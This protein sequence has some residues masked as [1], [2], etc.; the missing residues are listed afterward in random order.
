[1]IEAGAC[2]DKFFATPALELR[3]YKGIK[4]G[5]EVY[6]GKWTGFLASQMTAY[7]CYSLIN[8]TTLSLP[9]YTSNMG[10]PKISGSTKITEV[11]DRG[12]NLLPSHW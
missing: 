5:K 3:E 6:K 12:F 4:R 2:D 11:D 8:F 7:S 10:T 1:M 9:P